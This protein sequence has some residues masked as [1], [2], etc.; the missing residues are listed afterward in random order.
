MKFLTEELEDRHCEVF[1]DFSFKKDDFILLME[2]DTVDIMA[3]KRAFKTLSI[4]NTIITFNDGESGLEYLELKKK[5]PGVIILDLSLPKLSGIEF[6]DVWNNDE[7]IKNIPVIVMTVSV[8]EKDRNMC[9]VRGVNA[10][11]VKS[12]DYFGFVKTLKS[13]LI[14]RLLD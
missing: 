9:M 10:Y 6:L 5:K 2:D 3:L 14:P 7:D 1:N 4:N 11:M 13:L 12:I 8:Y